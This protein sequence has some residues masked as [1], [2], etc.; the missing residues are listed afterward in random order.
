MSRFAASIALLL[1]LACRKHVD[2]RPD[3]LRDILPPMRAAIEKFH[4]DN[5]RYPHSLN[6][7]VPKYLRRVP[8]DPMTKSATTWRFDTEETVTPSADFTTATATSETVITDVHSGAG[9]PYSDF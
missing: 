7:L 8:V 6:E 3:A 1:A 5:G 9:K 2:H 4:H